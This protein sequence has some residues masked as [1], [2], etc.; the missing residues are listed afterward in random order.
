MMNILL[1]LLL[2]L[3]VSLTYCGQLLLR[4]L[5]CSGPGTV[6]RRRFSRH[7]PVETV[8][9]PTWTLYHHGWELMVRKSLKALEQTFY[10][11]PRNLKPLNY[12]Y[13][14]P[15]HDYDN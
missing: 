13:Y 9:S 1:L 6:R 8:K 14:S 11:N 10:E 2:L 7:V 5:S 4:V 15:N 12:Y 3:P